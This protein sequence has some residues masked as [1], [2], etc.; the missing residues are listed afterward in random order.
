ME[1]EINETILNSLI[2]EVNAIIPI[3]RC[4]EYY[5]D[6]CIM[7]D[8]FFEEAR[9]RFTEEDYKNGQLYAG[10]SVLTRDMY[11]YL[12]DRSRDDAALFKD[13]ISEVSK[14]ERKLHGDHA[15]PDYKGLDLKFFPKQLASEA[16]MG[17]MTLK[18]LGDRNIVHEWTFKPGKRLFIKFSVKFRDTICGA[19][20]PYEKFEN[21][22]IGQADLPKSIAA[23]VL[24]AGFSAATF[25][26]PLAIYLSILL[27]K[28]GL[29]TYCEP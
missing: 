25:W 15:F 16:A 3:A 12:V 5:M 20:G 19:D 24:L 1:T 18:P 14:E 4:P 6:K 27:V 26:Y 13:V 29:K 2:E 10:L 22:L 8:G 21:G 7:Q 17:S 11:L 23:T 9:L 28:T